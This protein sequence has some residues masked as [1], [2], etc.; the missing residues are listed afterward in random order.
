[1][2]FEEKI[3]IEELIAEWKTTNPALSRFNACLEACI[4]NK[5]K[6]L[7]FLIEMKYP[8]NL[9]HLLERCTVLK[10]HDILQQLLINFKNEVT[11]KTLQFCLEIS[12]NNFDFK[13]IRLLLGP[14]KDCHAINAIEDENV[15]ADVNAVDEV[16]YDN[17]EDEDNDEDDEIV[18]ELAADAAEAVN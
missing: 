12:Q 10:H 1:M 18:V 3:S 5:G 6:I 16:N 4:Q 17:G 14:I 13:M 2:N 8:Y 9:H 15:I 11:D 7:F